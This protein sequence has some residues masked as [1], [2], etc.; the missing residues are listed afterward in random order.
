MAKHKNCR[1]AYAEGAEGRKSMGEQ[2]KRKRKSS[3]GGR[4]KMR[5]CVAKNWILIKNA[6]IPCNMHAQRLACAPQNCVAT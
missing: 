4:H 1:P 6:H 2:R 3:L 5:K